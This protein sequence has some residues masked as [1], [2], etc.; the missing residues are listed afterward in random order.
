MLFASLED[1][2]SALILATIGSGRK[3]GFRPNCLRPSNRLSRREKRNKEIKMNSTKL[4]QVSISIVFVVLLAVSSFG[5]TAKEDIAAES[6]LGASQAIVGSWY[7]TVTSETFPVP[8]K[9][10]ITFSEG[11][12]LVASAQ[13]DIL[14]DAPAGVAPIGTAAHGAWTRTSNRHFLFTFRQILYNA[15]GSYAGGA[16][17]RN[18]GRLD[19][20]GNHMSGQLVVQYYDANDQVVF[21]GAGAFTGTRIVAESLAP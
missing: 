8:F 6:S 2:P 11:G 15:D 7:L 14:L 20:S 21:T 16:K 10:M 3:R 18:A 4:H 12:G 17:I 19:S 5:Q 13:G 9:G 1:E